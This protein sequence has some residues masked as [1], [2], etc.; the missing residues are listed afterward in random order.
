MRRRGL[1]LIELL[2]VIAIIAILIGLLVPAIQKVREASLRIRS[3]NNV[4]QFSLAVLTFADSREGRLPSVDHGILE[5][6]P[7]VHQSAALV[8]Q[9]I[10]PGNGVNWVFSWERTFLSPADPSVDWF[11]R[12]DAAARAA[13]EPGSVAETSFTGFR[14]TSYAANAQVFRERPTYPFSIPD[15]VSNTIF[16]CERYADCRLNGSDYSDQNVVFAWGRSRASQ[17]EGVDQVYPVPGAGGV[18]QPSRLGATFQ[19]RPLWHE[20]PATPEGVL[21][22]L[23]NPPVGYCD[24]SVPQTPHTS[25][26]VVGMG[27][28][29]VRTVNRGTAPGVFWSLVTPNGSEVVNE[30]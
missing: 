30:W 3:Q 22:L 29:S 2:I 11:V 7:N 24:P 28:G 20:R 21:E 6:Q 14:P 9:T 25:G 12:E 5:G 1:T 23:N 13:L 10:H 17:S 26:M 8:L 19:S 18:S 27:D 4:K 15:G 16:Y